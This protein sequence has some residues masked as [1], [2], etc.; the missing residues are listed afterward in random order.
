MKALGL[1]IVFFTI[2]HS[3]RAPPPPAGEI[4]S[5]LAG[6]SGAIADAGSS[7]LSRTASSEVGSVMAALKST[8]KISVRDFEALFHQHPQDTTILNMAI[9]RLPRDLSVAEYRNL[10]GLEL[11]LASRRRLAI[12]FL[13]AHPAEL[14]ET[15]MLIDGRALPFSDLNVI[16]SSVPKVPEKIMMQLLL[17]DSV[18]QSDAISKVNAIDQAITKMDHPTVASINLIR[19]RTA[20]VEKGARGRLL[21]DFEQRILL[22][23]EQNGEQILIR[24]RVPENGAAFKIFLQR[25][26]QSQVMT[27]LQDMK[28]AAIDKGNKPELTTA[29]I[30]SLVGKYPDQEPILRLISEF[31]V[32]GD[33]LIT[34]VLRQEKLKLGKMTPALEEAYMRLESQIW[35]N[36]LPKASQTE[37]R[38]AFKDLSNKYKDPKST[39]A[40]KKV[41]SAQLAQIAKQFGLNHKAEVAA[42]EERARLLS[43]SAFQPRLDNDSPFAVP[44]PEQVSEELESPFARLQLN[45]DASDNIET[46]FNQVAALGT[47][48][49]HAPAHADSVSAGHL[50]IQPSVGPPL[51]QARAPASPRHNLASVQSVKDDPFS[52]LPET[53]D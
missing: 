9:H 40:E 52:F 29:Q 44:R 20:Y 36:W 3:V 11:P 47:S 42:M 30:T 23:M 31:S 49:N 24:E 43:P 32:P 10:L 12:D 50:V 21:E 35:T 27:M 28:T 38:S 34:M 13:K 5:V 51:P 7:S 46:P 2:L 45:G 17:R 15:L 39:A 26:S 14:P 48:V 8:Q 53:L 33:R 4:M 41:L 25:K 16:L 18:S 6:H 37:L 22:K 1:G 19:S